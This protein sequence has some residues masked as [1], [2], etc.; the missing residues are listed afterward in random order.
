[1]TMLPSDSERIAAAEHRQ[2]R[3]YVTVRDAGRVGFLLGPYDTYAGAHRNVDRGR[4]LAEEADS[5]AVFFAY[6]VSSRPDPCRTVF[7]S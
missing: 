3:F 7:G 6:G 1:M 4:K 2:A 5:W